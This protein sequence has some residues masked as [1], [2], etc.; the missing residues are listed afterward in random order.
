MDVT[1]NVV[2]AA[3]SVALMGAAFLTFRKRGARDSRA[4]NLTRIPTPAELG[5]WSAIGAFFTF[6]A[7]LYLLFYTLFVPLAPLSP[8]F[9]RGRALFYTLFIWSARACVLSMPFVIVQMPVTGLRVFRFA[10]VLV[11]VSL[12]DTFFGPTLLSALFLP[13]ALLILLMTLR[14]DWQQ[15]GRPRAATDYEKAPLPPLMS[16]ST[17][18]AAESR[19]FSQGPGGAGAFAVPSLSA[20]ALFANVAE[21]VLLALPA[22]FC[23]D[24]AVHAFLAA[25]ALVH[26]GFA[27]LALTGESSFT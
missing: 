14:L 12:V 16:V 7:G 23:S 2:L 17:R 18:V 1:V 19:A 26:A 15:H 8:T 4:S 24:A 13:V 5:R 3:A 11:A 6:L 25:F 27:A 9:D 20:R 10:L 21:S 22:L